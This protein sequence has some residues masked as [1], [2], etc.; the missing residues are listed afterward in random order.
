MQMQME[1]QGSGGSQQPSQ[2]QTPNQDHLSPGDEPQQS[3]GSSQQLPLPSHAAQR[4][5]TDSVSTAISDD[6]VEI[7]FP[8]GKLNDSKRIDYVLQEAP[9]E[10][11]NEYIFALSSHVCYW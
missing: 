4:A 3:S 8:L 7:D 9:L 11:I 6:M 2:S 10:F 1:R 5:R